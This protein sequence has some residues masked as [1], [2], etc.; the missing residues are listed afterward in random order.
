[1][2]MWLA[3]KIQTYVMHERSLVNS[4]RVKYTGATYTLK[5]WSKSND[6]LMNEYGDNRFS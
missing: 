6:R 1:M 2:F 5:R 3:C 4:H